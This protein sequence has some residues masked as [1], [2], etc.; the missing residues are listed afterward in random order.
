[1]EGELQT[2]VGENIRRL[3]REGGFSQEGFGAHIGW[4]RTFVGAVERGERNLTLKT[5]ERLSQQLGVH[6]F[7]LLWDRSGVAVVL[8][9]GEVLSL[10]PG[11]ARLPDQAAET[12]KAAR[13]LGSGK[14][15]R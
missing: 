14:R 5:V 6:P 12:P 7:E 1:M 2:V 15:P 9:Q 10:E 3:R 8:G 4:H 11:V 13:K